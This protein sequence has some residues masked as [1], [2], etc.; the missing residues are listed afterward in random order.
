[1]APMRVD[2]RERHEDEAA[3]MHERM[4]ENEGAARPRRRRPVHDP[5]AVIEDVDIERAGAPARPGTPPCLPLDTR[6]ETEKRAGR[7]VGAGL[8]NHI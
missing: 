4:G 1:M 3:P 7:A 6:E 2:L 8:D 5:A